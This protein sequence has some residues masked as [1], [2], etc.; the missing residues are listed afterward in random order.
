MIDLIKLTLWNTPATACDEGAK[1]PWDDAEFSSRMLENHLSQEH[2][3]ASRRKNIIR[4]QTDWLANQLQKP[5]TILDLG[6]GPGFYTY[7]LAE[8]GHQCTGVDFSPAAIKYARQQ[9]AGDFLNLEY[10]LSD[11]RSY[12][13]EQKF[14]CIIMTFGEFNV[15]TRQDASAILKNCSEMLRE[16]GLLVLEAHC[17]EAVQAIGKAQPTWQRHA[18]G[19]FSDKPHLCLQ[20]N[21]WNASAANALSRY[22]IVD[23]ASA[24]VQHY[25]H[26]MQA[27]THEEYEKML[28]TANLPLLQIL[29][30]EA[31]PVGPDF[32]GKLQT[33]ICRKN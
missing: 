28:L 27:Y 25:A 31:W 16:N 26:F 21:S 12:K 1:I 18:S 3:W 17:F 13:T 2:D 15:F 24:K 6:C 4:K 30:E 19:L 20:E 7:N 23:A 32:F 29:T 14:D 9:D 10:V 5:S 11:I 33:L 8:L 22:F